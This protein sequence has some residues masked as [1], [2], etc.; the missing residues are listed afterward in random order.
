MVHYLPT[1][2]NDRS[3]RPQAPSSPSRGEI[4]TGVVC[5]LVIVAISLGVGAM[6]A[7]SFATT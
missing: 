7:I 2:A 5:A 3:L 1:H 4:L 6:F